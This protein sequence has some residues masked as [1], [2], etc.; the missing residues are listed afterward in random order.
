MKALAAR[1]HQITVISPNPLKTPVP[2]YKDVDLSFTYKVSKDKFDFAKMDQTS[3]YDFMQKVILSMSKLPR[4]QLS[5]PQMRDFIRSNETKYDLV[6]LEALVYQSYHGLIHHVG[7][8]PFIGVVPYESFWTAAEAVGNPTNPAFIPDILLPYGNHMTFYERL[9]NT[10]F[11]LWVRY[12]MHAEVLPEQEAVMRN[13]FGSSPPPVTDAERNM[14][15]LILSSN[16]VFNYPIP[17]VPSIVTIHSLHVK[18][19]TDP[20]PNDLQ[21][22]LDKAKDGV[23]YFSLGSSVRSDHMPEEKRRVFIEAFSELPQKILW[24]WESDILPGQPPN[25]KSGK[26]LPQQD[27]LA[28]PNIKLFITQCG[29]QSFQEAVY[30]G[31]PILGIP[32]F[33][34]QKYNAKKIITE[35]VGLQLP[36]KE[37][38]KQTLLTSINAIL[39][40]TKYRDNMKKLS[41]LSKDEPQSAL[42]RAVWWTEYVIRHNGAKHLRSA[43]LDL[44]WYQYLLLDVAA[45][46]FLL[47]AITVLVSYLILKTAYRYLTAQYYNVKWKSD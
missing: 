5:S 40:N 17:L 16:S 35:E 13:V 14:S 38:T 47:A 8:P 7:S 15:L 3:G 23:I 18:T 34:D 26:W 44:A 11:W 42:N 32:F 41:A 9:Q 19:T 36:F 24:K 46:L 37:M 28:H 31:V 30:H 4:L 39:N 22:F 25:V 6:I 21:K 12:K 2:N 27:I 20:L 1:G 45:F 43:A 33:A 10:L 29:L